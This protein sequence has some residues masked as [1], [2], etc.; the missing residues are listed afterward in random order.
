M[1]AVSGL[2][3]REAT[4]ALPTYLLSKSYAPYSKSMLYCRVSSRLFVR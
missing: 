2:A 3:D 4:F 1:D